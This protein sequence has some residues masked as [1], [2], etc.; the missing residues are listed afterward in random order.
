LSPHEI[1]SVAEEA[2]IYGYPLVLMDVM[3]RLHTAVPAAAEDGAPINQFAHSRFL[4]DADGKHGSRPHA[5]SLRSRAWLDVSRQPMILTIP[6]SDRY[7]VFS[8]FSAWGDL[9]DAISPRTNGVEGD[10]IA[11]VGPRWRSHV[12]DGLKPI[13]A[14]S[15]MI[16][17]NGRIQSADDEDLQIVHSMQDRFQLTPLVDW[18]TTASPHAAPFRTDIDKCMTPEEQVAS[19]PAPTFYT[20]LSILMRKHRPHACDAP[21]IRQLAR[22][23]FVPSAEFAFEALAPAT[24]EAMTAA[25][26]EAKLTIARAAEAPPMKLNNW[27]YRVHPRHADTNYLSRAAAARNGFRNSMAEDVVAF[28]AREDRAGDPLRGGNEYVIHFD[29]ERVPPVNAFWSITAYDS[30]QLLA[31]NALHRHAIGDRNRLRLNSDHSFSIYIQHTWPG[32]DK[33]SNWLP[34]PKDAFELVLQLYWPK[35][36][37]LTGIWRP[38]ALTRVH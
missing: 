6:P 12:P 35:N 25:V 18:G 14:P 29:Q 5:D 16:W 30:R 17:I 36:E 4:P 2:Y 21:F 7:F 20:R 32:T 34:A 22:I 23:G 8:L 33:D 38:P 26:A 1:Q 3:R 15:D 27:I 37:V 9:F 13:V 11:L 24:A 28:Q 10:R 31:V 19:L